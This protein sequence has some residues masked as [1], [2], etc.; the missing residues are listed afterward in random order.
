MTFERVL[1]LLLGNLGTLVTLLAILWG[2]YKRVWVWG[3]YASELKDANKK[4]ETRLERAVGT[5]EGGT[6][7]ARS[8]A[9]TARL[10]TDLA[11]Q[12]Q[13]GTGSV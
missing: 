4:L 8:A 1:E 11:T 13:T 6:T 5:A 2:G 12:R 7:L 9:E 3:W 10:A